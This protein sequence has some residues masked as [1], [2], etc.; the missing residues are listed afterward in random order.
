[1]AVSYSINILRDEHIL[2][3]CQLEYKTDDAACVSDDR[4]M[5]H[6]AICESSRIRHLPQSHK[7]QYGQLLQT[8]K[9]FERSSD[10]D[11]ILQC[12]LDYQDGNGNVI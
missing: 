6:V 1:M 8:Y 5:V 3:P 12:S 11:N 10:Y 9:T 7:L 4:E 2:L